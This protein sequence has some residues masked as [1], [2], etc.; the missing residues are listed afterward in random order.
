MQNSKPTPNIKRKKQKENQIII[1]ILTYVNL[2]VFIPNV[3]H[4]WADDANGPLSNAPTPIPL[5]PKTKMRHDL[6]AI[7]W[8]LMQVSTMLHPRIKEAVVDKAISSSF[9]EF[10]WG[11][12]VVGSYIVD[13]KSV[14]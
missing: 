13:R 8:L 11:V 10:A 3:Y 5:D 12:A 9:L 7:C 2:P 14:V 1:C 4:C 6:T